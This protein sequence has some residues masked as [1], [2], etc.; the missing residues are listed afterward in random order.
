MKPIELLPA[1]M[2]AELIRVRMEPVTGDEQ[3]VVG[4]AISC[5]KGN[6]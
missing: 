1:Y 3:P 4:R 6:E 5:E 2:R